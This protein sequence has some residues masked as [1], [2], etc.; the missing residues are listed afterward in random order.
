MAVTTGSITG[1]PRHERCPHCH[2]TIAIDVTGVRKPNVIEMTQ[3]TS[4][5]TPFEEAIE[6]AFGPADQRKARG[7]RLRDERAKWRRGR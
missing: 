3:P 5:A 4:S 7:L 2:Q 6:R 1:G